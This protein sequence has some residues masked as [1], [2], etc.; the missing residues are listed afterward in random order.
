LFSPAAARTVLTRT[1][2][3]RLARGVPNRLI[4]ALTPFA[5]Q[6]PPFPVEVWLTTPLR[7]ASAEQGRPDFM[8]LYAGQGAPQLKHRRVVDLMADLSSPEAFAPEI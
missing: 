7:R 8:A 2:S 6:L 3:G 1:Y 5:D 4:E